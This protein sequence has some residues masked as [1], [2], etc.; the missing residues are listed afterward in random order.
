MFLK[1]LTTALVVCGL[2]MVFAVPYVL[3]SKPPT[4]DQHALAQYGVRVLTYFGITC[5]VWI[6]AAA[7]AVALMRR[8][9][10]E[11]LEDKG[12]NIKDLIE[13]TL[14]DHERKE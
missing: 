14:R 3:G 11:Y 5:F 9:R 7:C 10:T 13:G 8:V 12:H 6:G 2:A 4:D 1:V